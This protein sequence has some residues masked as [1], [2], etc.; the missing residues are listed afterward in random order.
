MNYATVG[1]DI[2]KNVF[3]LHWIEPETGEIIRIQVKRA[4]FL[5]YF[6][7]REPCLVGMEA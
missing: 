5:E 2:A 4:S 7:N 3:Q 6:V 1:V